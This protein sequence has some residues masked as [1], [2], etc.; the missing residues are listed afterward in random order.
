MA[1]V[2]GAQA[3]PAE[4][5]KVILGVTRTLWDG[6]SAPVICQRAA[7]QWEIDIP[8]GEYLR[9]LWMM[10]ADGR[11]LL[12]LPLQSGTVPEDEDTDDD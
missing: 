7:D 3:H 10:D 1:G 12:D 6:Q 4:A 9:T 5:M 11:R 8:E 2:G